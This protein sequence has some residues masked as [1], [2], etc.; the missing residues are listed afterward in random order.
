MQ[1]IG[2][3]RIILWKFICDVIQLVYGDDVRHVAFTSSIQNITCI[4]SYRRTGQY[5]CVR[6]P[7]TAAVG[8]SFSLARC[9]IRLSSAWTRKRWLHRSTPSRLDRPT[10]SP[11]RPASEICETCWPTCRQCSTNRLVGGMRATLLFV[12]CRCCGPNC[13]RYP[14][15]L[16][17]RM[18]SF[19]RIPTELRPAK[20][21]VSITI[22]RCSS[23]PKF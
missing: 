2:Y 14:K 8:S 11:W 9:S 16:R 17:F 18:Q 4:V 21:N 10:S 3:S 12:G 22:V 20:I 1:H 6:R 7:R 23:D 13:S 15:S 5:S 19:S